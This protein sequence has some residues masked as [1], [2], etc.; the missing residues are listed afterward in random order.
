MSELFDAFQLLLSTET[1]NYSAF[2]HQLKRCQDEL[3]ETESVRS[4]GL[5]RLAQALQHWSETEEGSADVLVL[6]RQVIR[7]HRQR[8]AAPVRLWQRLSAEEARTGLWGAVDSDEPG[9]IQLMADEWH[10]QWLQGTEEIDHIVRRRSNT[11]VLGDGLLYAMT[12]GHFA[13]YQSLA[14]RAAV[15]G[16]LFCDP[17]STLLVT[18]PTGMGKSLAILEPAWHASKGGRIKGGTTLVVVPTVSLA[19]DQQRSALRFFESV[20][21]PEY[22][23]QAWTADTPREMRAAICAGIKYGTLPILYTSPEALMQSDLYTVCLEAASQKTINWLVVDEA[24]L[25]ET[26]GAGFR[27]RFQF[28]AA[29]RE[30]LLEHSGGQLRTLLLSATVSQ[31]CMALLRQ[32]FGRDGSF[33]SVQANRLRPEPSYWSHFSRDSSTREKRVLEALWHLPRPAILYVSRVK[34][35]EHWQEILLRQSFQ[36]LGVFTGE[37]PPAKRQQ[38]I[39]AWRDSEIDLMVATSAFGVGI[40]KSDVRTI[41]HACLPENVD[42]FYQEVGRAGRDGYSAISLL[43]TTEEDYRV[44]EGMTWAA[45][46]TEEQ[47]ANRWEGMHRTGR[48]LSTEHAADLLVDTNASPANEPDMRRS[49][50][51]R[52]WNEHTLLLMQRAGLLQIVDAR[53]DIAPALNSLNVDTSTLS[54][55]DWLL[56]RLL[57]P[58]IT[59]YPENPEFIQL[60]KEKRREEVRDILSALTKME[61]IA[62]EYSGETAQRCLAYELSDLYPGCARA[63]GGCPYCRGVQNPPYEQ[64]LPLSVDIESGKPNAELLAADLRELMGWRAVLHVTW[65]GLRDLTAQKQ[66]DEL[67][68]ELIEAGVQQIILPEELSSDSSWLQGLIKRVANQNATPHQ[69]LTEEDLE[70]L[71]LYTVPTGIVYPAADIP[72]GLFYRRLSKQLRRWNSQ[73]VPLVHIVHRSLFLESE[74]GRFVDRI[75]GMSEKLDHLYMHLTRWKNELF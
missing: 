66:I 53:E 24:H 14:Q 62:K 2:I 19:I 16:C 10:P 29:Y 39:R 56:V 50:K 38:L 4:Y 17:G 57:D 42:R 35:A 64:S 44:A 18:M 69:I 9:M 51:N 73:R 74:R 75:E 71:P 13:G 34:D 11:H 7:S 68:V 12:L 36:R 21:S 28:L 58:V 47:A 70:F 26:W 49:D 67:L 43:C 25:V 54:I 41:I 5:L 1:S 30:R 8:L 46:I 55:R 27:T 60:L 32:L 37:T 61:T 63:C 3:T 6:L 40:D 31:K 52:E 45:R 48:V 23:P 15:Q 33:F 72:A 59:A 22:L 65:D 20:T